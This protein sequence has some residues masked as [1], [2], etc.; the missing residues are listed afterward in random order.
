MMSIQ[1]N[2]L[3]ITFSAAVLIATTSV[4]TTA[5]AD[6][7]GKCYE[8]NSCKGQS[9]CATADSKC[10]GQNQCKGQGWLQLTEKKCHEKNGVFKPFK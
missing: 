5:K 3:A 7:K 2:R 4:A 9:A 10:A 8:V 1:S 6:K